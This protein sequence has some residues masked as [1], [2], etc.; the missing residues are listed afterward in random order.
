M[1]QFAVPLLIASTAVSAIGAIQ[2]GK[3]QKRAYDYNAQINE[4]NAKA[5]DQAADQLV[6][7]NEVDVKRFRNDFDDLQASTSQ[8]FRY[9]GWMA[10]TGT[11]LKVALANAQ[12]ADEEV[13]TMRYNAKVGKQELKEQGVQQRMQANLNRMYGRNAARAGKFQAMGSLLSGGYKY[14]TM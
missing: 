4:R 5:N 6:L 13:A 8:A 3:D 10:D 1:A 12:Q 14:A 9:N 2:A 11:P 7:Q